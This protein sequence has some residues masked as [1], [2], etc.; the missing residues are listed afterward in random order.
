MLLDVEGAAACV[1]G[2]LPSV[3]VFFSDAFPKVELLRPLSRLIYIVPSPG[4]REFD[5]PQRLQSVC[6][7]LWRLP[8]L[9][10]PFAVS[11]SVSKFRRYD[12]FDGCGVLILDYDYTENSQYMRFRNVFFRMGVPR[13]AVV[14]MEKVVAVVESVELRL[15]RNSLVGKCALVTKIGLAHILISCASQRLST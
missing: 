3:L 7:L 14:G 8:K 13:G 4:E 1:C 12:G 2:C 9:E 6:V 15:C 10:V 11:Q 5:I